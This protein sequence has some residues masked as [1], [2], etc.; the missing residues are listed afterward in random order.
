MLSSLIGPFNEGERLVLACEVDGGKPRPT[1]TWW[2]ESVLLDDSYEI[3]G[4]GT[5]RNEL[6]IQALQRHDLMAVFSCQASNNNISAPVY[7]QVT[8]DLN[9]KSSQPIAIELSAFASFSSYLLAYT[10]DC[11]LQTATATHS[12]LVCSI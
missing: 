3:T 10:G 1:L 2:R 8:V 5:T 11:E 9:C 4:S 12:L 7:S 6:E